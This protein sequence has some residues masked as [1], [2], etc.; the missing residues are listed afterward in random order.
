MEEQKD[1]SGMLELVTDPAFCVKDGTITLVNQAARQFLLNPGSTVATLLG[2]DAEEYA[3]FTGGCLWLTLELSGCPYHASVTRM[4]HFDLFVI[5]QSEKQAELRTMALTA[6]GFREPLSDV[7]AIADQLFPSCESAEE[8]STQALISRMN[9]RLSQL[10]RMVCNMADAH[11]YSAD[12][13]PRMTCQ[14][15]CAVIKE[16]FDRAQLLVEATGLHLTYT[17]PQDPITCMIAPDRLERAIY[18][19]LSNAMKHTSPGGHIDAKLTHRGSK[20]YLSIQ[21]DGSGIPSPMLG[22]VYSRY[23]RQPGI[24]SQPVGLGLGMVLVRSTAA[25][26]GGTVLIDQPTDSGTRITISIAV[27]K[28]QGSIVRSNRL[29]VDYAGEQDHGLV[30]LSDVL[31]EEFYTKK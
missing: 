12:S 14:N 31:P 26:H 13:Q 17:G 29:T 10:H 27:Q 15:V 3:A 16:I 24:E 18:N 21:D 4:D 6:M 5:D 8:P 20:L 23:R 9:R 7:M 28:S 1:I 25:S 11:Q 2:H 30:E 22:S 19:I